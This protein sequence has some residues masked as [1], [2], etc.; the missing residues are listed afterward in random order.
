MGEETIKVQ[1]TGGA[2]IEAPAGTTTVEIMKM[3]WEKLPKTACIA[4]LDGQSL[5]LN[6]PLSTDGN[7]DFLSFD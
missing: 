6:R 5:E 4:E 1:I 3:A 2:V 7:L